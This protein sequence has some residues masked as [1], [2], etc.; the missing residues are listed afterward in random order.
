MSAPCRL[1]K[2]PKLGGAEA[3]KTKDYGLLP[4]QI[5]EWGPLLFLKFYQVSV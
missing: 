5:R 2:A 3:F 1:A 4:V